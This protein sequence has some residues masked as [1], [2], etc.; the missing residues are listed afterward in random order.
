MA[1]C[2]E[3]V[4]VQGEGPLG[5]FDRLDEGSSTRLIVTGFEGVFLDL[6]VGFAQDAIRMR[7]F[8]VIPDESPGE[9]HESRGG[10]AGVVE[11]AELPLLRGCVSRVVTNERSPPGPWNPRGRA[12][13][14]ALEARK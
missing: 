5:G 13:N 12:S 10:C 9:R 8:G 14:T 7:T 11:S 2:F 3:P 1:S 6:V 4:R